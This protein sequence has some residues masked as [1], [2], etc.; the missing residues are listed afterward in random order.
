MVNKLI[1]SVDNKDHSA[2]K[3]SAARTTLVGSSLYQIGIPEGLES[4]TYGSLYK[5]LAERKMIPLGL[6]R[7]VFPH[8]KCGPKANKMPYVFTNPPKDTELFSCDKIFVLSQTPVKIG[9]A[10]KVTARL[11][12][13]LLLFLRSN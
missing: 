10:S 1:G 12:C 9:K 6:L 8:T 11:V 4:K 7:G 3:K 13:S 2:D 5:L